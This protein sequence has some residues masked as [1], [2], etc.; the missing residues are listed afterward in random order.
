MT[1]LDK[2]HL[3]ISFPPPMSNEVEY[4]AT[5]TRTIILTNISDNRILIDDITLRFQS[6]SEQ[7]ALKVKT[8]CGWELEPN[9]L[10]ELQIEITPT[11]L[12]LKATNQFDVKARYRIIDAG[13][14]GSPQLEIHPS[15]S[16]II[17]REPKT[18]VGRVFISLKQPQDL[19]LGRRMAIMARRAGLIP[20][21]KDDN[22]HISEDIWK[23]TIEPALRSSDICI[24]IWTDNTDWKAAGV[25][26]EIN[27]CRDAKIPEALFLEQDADIPK[28]YA[29]TDIEYTRFDV[30]NSGKAFADGMDT[31]R[32]RLQ[33]RN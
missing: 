3:A 6:D 20:F 18:H 17:I 21:L 31:L 4:Y 26:R 16:Y 9:A 14:V 22:Q 8:D 15:Q 12:Y 7:A 28:L 30:K 23:D 19:D 10:H 13:R 5:I 27:I 11:P 25:E 1:K 32:H 2:N 24:V 29:D 33:S